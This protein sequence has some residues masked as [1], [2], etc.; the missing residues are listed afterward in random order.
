MTDYF[1][2]DTHFWH[3]NI[4]KMGR[5]QFTTI[6][7]HNEHIIAQWNKVVRPGDKIYHLGD[8]AFGPLEKI[9][10]I[11][12]R[13]NGYKLLVAGNHDMRPTEAYL[14]MGFARV[15]GV[16]EY[17]SMVLSHMPIH[18]G[19][20]DYRYTYN[21]HG[22]THRNLVKYPYSDELDPRY[23]CVSCEQVNYTPISFEQI[24]ER[25]KPNFHR[26]TNEKRQVIAVEDLT[27]KE[28]EEIE[29]LVV[30]GEHDHLNSLL[31]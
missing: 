16:M 3:K 31:D 4:L 24:I 20:V 6:E 11:M 5:E 1:I 13:L 14:K 29:K 15:A 27:V 28:I 21:I 30:G 7:E 18:T 17:K 25:Y 22:H 12:P 9:Q 26:L 19:Q 10:E 8:L 2:G 23:I